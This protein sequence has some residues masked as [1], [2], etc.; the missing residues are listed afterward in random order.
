M[1]AKRFICQLYGFKKRSLFTFENVLQKK[2]SK[3]SMSLIKGKP[4]IDTLLS[5]GAL[6]LHS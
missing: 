5:F 4:A 1:K 3:Y 2:D 6:E